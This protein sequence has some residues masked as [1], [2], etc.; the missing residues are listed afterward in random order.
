MAGI[1]L[2]WLIL[3]SLRA[4]FPPKCKHASVTPLK[5]KP[6]RDP[7]VSVNFRPITHLMN[8]SKSLRGFFVHIYSHTLLSHVIS[9][10]CNQLIT[11]IS[12]L[13]P[14]S[15][16]CLILFIT[17]PFFFHLSTLVLPLIPLAIMPSYSSQL[18]HVQFGIIDF[19][20]KWLKYGLSDWSLLTLH[21]TFVLWCPPRFS[22]GSHPFCILSLTYCF[23]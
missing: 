16:T 19:S 11:D 22:L 2:T 4:L 20:H 14:F 1:L 12:L 10:L 17:Q 23:N 15:F 8:I 5:K 3:L 9:I 18:P 13:K 6:G 7:T 21:L